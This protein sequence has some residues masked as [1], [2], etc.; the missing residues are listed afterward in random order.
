MSDSKPTILFAGGGT[1]GHLSP[2]LAVAE[3][4]AGR[5]EAPNVHFACSNR[6]IDRSMLEQAGVAFT[7]LT[8]QPIPRTRLWRWPAFFW[9]WRSSVRTAGELL[10]RLNVQCVVA[11]GGFVSGPVVVAARRA[12]VP[13][14]LINL[15]AVPGK[16]NRYLAP[17]CNRVFSVF[18]TTDLPVTQT[19]MVPLPL[20]ARAVGPADKGAARTELGLP[21][22]RPVLLITGGSQG[23]ES[24]NLAV[25]A[26]VDR[27]D[28]ARHL[29][30]WHVLHI[31]GSDMAE[32]MR[33]LY[34]QRH[35]NATVMSF[36]P[37]MGLAW[38]AAELAICRAG[39]NT[40]AEVAANATPSVFLPYPYHADQHQKL[41]AQ[42]LVDAG[43]AVMFDDLIDPQANADQL[44]QPLIDLMTDA[45]RRQ[46][47][48]NALSSTHQG[49][50]AAII[51]D[52]IIS[53]CNAM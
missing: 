28:F 53:M 16:A 21:A 50:G 26:L 24:V 30:D 41:N 1:G 9:H 46:Q 12:G 34:G 42:P 31:A 18:A 8:V 11:M 47:M 23:A 22:D 14:V 3:R 32:R 49:D 27:D 25:C 6:P 33:G 44:A 38:S 17:R 35:I 51:A 5:D 2:S 7:R 37:T 13:I 40:V 52:Q 4:L 45:D 29:A 10:G 20:P 43:G 19:Q 15:D 39:A 48:R 36:C